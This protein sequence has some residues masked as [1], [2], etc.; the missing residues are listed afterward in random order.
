MSLTGRGRL[1][2]IV[3][4]LRFAVGCVDGA[5]FGRSGAIN[6]DAASYLPITLHFRP[7]RG[8]ALTPAAV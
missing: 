4:I 5:R 2:S 3:V 7:Y 6:P 8:V 1:A